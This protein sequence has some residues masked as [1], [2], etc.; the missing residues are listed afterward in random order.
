LRKIE[1]LYPASERRAGIQASV[2]AEVTIDMQGHVQDVKI[3]TSAG[4]AFDAAVI[5]ALRKSS[6]TPGYISDIAVPVRFQV[7]FRFN[8]N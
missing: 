7:P 1:P 8:L 5:E 4:A 3:I 6:F 2:L